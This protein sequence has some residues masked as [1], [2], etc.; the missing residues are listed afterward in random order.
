[1]ELFEEIKHFLIRERWNYNFELKHS[2]S[3]QDDL[4]IYGDDAYEILSKFCEKFNVDPYS[5]NLSEYFKPEPS[6]TDIFS[7]KKNYKKIDIGD[8]V[9][10]ARIGKFNS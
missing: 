6:W 4:K 9:A 8:L 10:A 7:S 5:I 1:M 2:T 3:L